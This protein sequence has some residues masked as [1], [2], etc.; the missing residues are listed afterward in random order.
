M[1]DA[2]GYGYSSA[3]KQRENAYKRL[4][5]YYLLNS[6]RLCGIYWLS[7]LKHPLNLNDQIFFNFA[8]FCKVPV[9]LVF[10]KADLFPG[11]VVLAKAIA[12]SHVLRAHAVVDPL[13]LLTSSKTDFGIQHLKD[14][15]MFRWPNQ[16]AGVAHA[17]SAPHA[18]PRVLL[19]GRPAHF[20][21]AL[22]SAAPDRR[23]AL[24]SGEAVDSGVAS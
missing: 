12:Y 3:T 16:Y 20:T 19:A 7:S 5:K 4:I 9:T 24:D 17:H 14:H 10:T 23:R 1:L 8:K 2:P 22:F 15:M 18:R 21:R 11:E 6:S 13:V